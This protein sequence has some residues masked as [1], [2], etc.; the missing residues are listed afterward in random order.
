MYKK[1]HT[2]LYPTDCKCFKTNFER[3][4]GRRIFAVKYA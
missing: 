4:V 2:K 3:P 1:M